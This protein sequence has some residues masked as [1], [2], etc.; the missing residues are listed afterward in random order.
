VGAI[1]GK[2]ILTLDTTPEQREQMLKRAVKAEFMESTTRRVELSAEDLLRMG[3]AAIAAIVYI[4]AASLDEQ[5]VLQRFGVPAERIRSSETQEHFLY[6][7][8]GLDLQLDSKGKEILQY[9]AP[10]KFD[11]LREPLVSAAKAEKQ[12]N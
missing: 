10:G 6:P 1:T 7:A 8:K 12:E 11:R 4:P 3:S 5:I 2:M 9:V